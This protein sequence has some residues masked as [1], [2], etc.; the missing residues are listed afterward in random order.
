MPKPLPKEESNVIDKKLE[1]YI[2]K[3]LSPLSI[4]DKPE[5]KEL[6]TSL[7]PR[8]DPPSS[9]TVK[10]R[11]H[12]ALSKMQDEL[13]AHIHDI[14]FVGLT[15][16]SWTSIATETYECATI[17]YMKCHPITGEWVLESKVLETSKIE[18]SH[19][20]EVIAKYLKDVKARWNLPDILAVS[21]NAAVEVKTFQLLGWDR[22]GC[23]G[24]LINLLVR[25]MLNEKMPRCLVA[26]GRALVSYMHRSSQAVYHF[27]KKQKLLMDEDHRHKLVNDVVTRWNSTCDM[28]ER[29][30]E[31]SAPLHALVQDQE[32]KGKVKDLK[33]NLFT[34]AEQSLAEKLVG[35]LQPFKTASQL[36]SAERSPTLSMVLPVLEQ[37]N[38]PLV[39]D[40]DESNEL[41]NLK[42]KMRKELGERFKAK[43]IYEKASALDPVTKGW[44]M[45]RMGVEKVK[46]ML[47]EELQK[48]RPVDSAPG[49]I[50]TEP[51]SQEDQPDLPSLPQKED[52]DE[53][54]IK[55][56]KEEE[57]EE[58]SEECQ[59]ISWIG[60]VLFVKEEKK[61]NTLSREDE[62][63]REVDL[64]LRENITEKEAGV[65]GA[66]LKWWGEKQRLYPNVARLAKRY[67]ACPASSVPSERIWSLAGNIVTKKRS[68]LS[69]ENINMLIFLNKN[70]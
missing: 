61:E 19:T 9:T 13:K 11:L 58:D 31:Q 48:L 62:L 21:D 16:D 6:L 35:I 14:E 50:K 51:D 40:A 36:L 5:F 22:I 64:Y 34:F 59:V 70:S 56:I 68:C 44:L 55:K 46:E 26:K 38:V 41:E 25:N 30:L 52:S 60:G 67:L 7:N 8:Y 42:R 47:V 18:G 2:I 23:F 29:L 54:P 12:K 15:H 53:V 17:H 33:P 69:P 28:L 39:A 66:A 32:L 45:M 65:Q 10:T 49:K 1:M 43:A 3:S 4:T 63:I 24:H 27:E 37:L 57:P 20:A